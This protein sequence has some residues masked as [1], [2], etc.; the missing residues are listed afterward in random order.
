M[1]MGLNLAERVAVVA[2]GRSGIGQAVVHALLAQG[3]RGGD[4]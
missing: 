1:I 4:S 3:A 2:G